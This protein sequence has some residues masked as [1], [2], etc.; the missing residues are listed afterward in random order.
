MTSHV[1]EEPIV[2]DDEASFDV[3]QMS[4]ADLSLE[5]QTEVS[6]LIR[7]C[8]STPEDFESLFNNFQIF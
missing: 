3:F 4:F 5:L 1:V 6:D 7:W 2:V 8:K